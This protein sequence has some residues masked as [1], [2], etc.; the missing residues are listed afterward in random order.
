MKH[1]QFSYE[2]NS[3]ATTI[4]WATAVFTL[5]GERHELAH[6][7]TFHP[8]RTVA[9]IALRIAKG[10]GVP[11]TSAV[12]DE[13]PSGYIAQF[14]QR[15]P[16]IFTLTEYKDIWDAKRGFEHAV[17]IVSE[18]IESLPFAV[19][20]ARALH[21]LY[22][23]H[24]ELGFLRRWN[25]FSFPMRHYWHLRL[26]LDSSPLIDELSDVEES[27]I[28][29]CEAKLLLAEPAWSA[30][31]LAGGIRDIELPEDVLIE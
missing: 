24:G 5:D 9:T 20:V 17:S 10:I 14:V 1:L 27:K 16:T 26:L 30:Q 12:F 6:A 29:E 23:R 3:E 22:R 7:Y 25:R 4:G 19:S 8:L 11:P 15:D 18:E 31:R 2:L 13:E 21:L 28:G